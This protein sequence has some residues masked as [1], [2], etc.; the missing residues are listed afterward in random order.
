MQH[1]ISVSEEE[2]TADFWQQHVSVPYSLVTCVD[3]Y[4]D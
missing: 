1:A 3:L 4:Q 2:L